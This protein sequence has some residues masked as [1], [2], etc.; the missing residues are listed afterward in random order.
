MFYL[1]GLSLNLDA[2]KMAETVAENLF[3]DEHHPLC[4]SHQDACE[5]ADRKQ[6]EGKPKLFVQRPGFARFLN[7]QFLIYSHIFEY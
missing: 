2:I 4:G 3:I 6:D 5:Q 1:L 7:S